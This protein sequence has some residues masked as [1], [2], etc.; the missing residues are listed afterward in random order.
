MKMGCIYSFTVHN[1]KSSTELV[2]WTHPCGN[3][4]LT[5]YVGPMQHFLSSEHI[6]KSLLSFFKVFEFHEDLHHSDS[7]HAGLQAHHNLGGRKKQHQFHLQHNLHR[8]L[9][10][11]HLR[12]QGHVIACFKDNQAQPKSVSVSVGANER[13]KCRGCREPYKYV[14]DDDEEDN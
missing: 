11:C 12:P 6:S 14:S 9:Q 3:H 10:L 8:R 5:W 13:D 4:H 7:S 2:C 1:S